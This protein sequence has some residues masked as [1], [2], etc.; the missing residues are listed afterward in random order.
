MRTF[1]EVKHESGYFQQGD[2][3]V[4]NMSTLDMV[5]YERELCLLDRGQDFTYSEEILISFM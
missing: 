3:H 1:K 5:N 2:G 4:S